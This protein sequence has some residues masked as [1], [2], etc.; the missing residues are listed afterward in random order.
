MPSPSSPYYLFGAQ[1]RYP[2]AWH[3]G[4]G[5]VPW[6][7]PAAETRELSGLGCVGSTVPGVKCAGSCCASGVGGF[8]LVESGAHPYSIRYPALNRTRLHSGLGDWPAYFPAGP[9]ALDP[10]V[11][12]FQEDLGGNYITRWNRARG[13]Q[14]GVLGDIPIW[15]GLSDNEK[16]VVALGGAAALAWWLW[17]RSGRAGP[18]GSRRLARATRRYARNPG[19]RRSRR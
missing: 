8:D 7:R 6:S 4:A 14:D 2:Y 1:R 16:K 12:G 5:G 18:R 19:S 11:A 17:K 9:E 15:S 10:G 3:G 13:I